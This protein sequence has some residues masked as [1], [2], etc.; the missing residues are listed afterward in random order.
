M[1]LFFE[2]SRMQICKKLLNQLKNFFTNILNFIIWHLFAGES[3][4]AVNHCTLVLNRVLC[5]TCLTT[6]LSADS[7]CVTRR[8]DWLPS[9]C[10]RCRTIQTFPLFPEMEFLDI[11]LTKHSCVVLHAIHSSF[12][13]QILQKTIVHVWHFVERKKTRQ[14]KV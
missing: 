4:Q 6:C 5:C 1:L 7:T 13:W 12:Y 14:T 10:A 11:S 8:G 9:S 2:N 3:H